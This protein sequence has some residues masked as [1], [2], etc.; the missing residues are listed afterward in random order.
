MFVFIIDVLFIPLTVHGKSEMFVFIHRCSLYSLTIHVVEKAKVCFH[1]RCSL[2]SLTV[3][4]K[5]EMF[6]FIVDVLFIP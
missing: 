1:R 5:S 3:H 4:G 6:V 2:Y